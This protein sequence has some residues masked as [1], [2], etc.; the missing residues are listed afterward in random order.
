MRISDWSSDVCSSDLRADT[1][2][3]TERRVSHVYALD[4]PHYPKPLFITDAAI[5]IYPDLDDKR[6]IVQ[7]AIDLCQAIGIAVPK[8]AILSAVETIDPTIT[9]TIEAAAICKMDDR[10]QITDGLLDGPTAF[11]NRSEKGRVGTA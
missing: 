5:N 11:D 6:D 7:N 10:G 8:V 4:V 1:G 2:L 9:S 3:R